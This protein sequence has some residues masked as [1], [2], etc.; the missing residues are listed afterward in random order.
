MNE[1][2]RHGT[3]NGYNT[4]RCRCEDCRD[5]Y[6][7]YRTANADRIKARMAQYYLDNRDRV[8]ERNKEY[9]RTHREQELMRA[10]NRNPEIG[11][12]STAR[13][14]ERNPEARDRYR[15][16][17]ASATTYVVTKRDWDR[18]CSRYGW[19]CAY[20]G[21]Q[22]KLTFDHVVPLSRGGAH[23]IGNLLPACLS[24]N[25]SKNN[26]FLVEWRR[27]RR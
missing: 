23:S 11:R 19:R 21:E 4:D 1:S 2:T 3:L 17:K 10:S 14:R 26:R 16:V 20:C 7:A 22:R 27:R 12:A 5:A 13:W 9:Y 18:L 15:L 8:L 6:R 25:C 24:C